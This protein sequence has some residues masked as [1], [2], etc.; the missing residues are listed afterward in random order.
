MNTG[1]LMLRRIKGDFIALITG[2]R[3]LK[4]QIGDREFSSKKY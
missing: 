2:F 4:E 1:S 3:V